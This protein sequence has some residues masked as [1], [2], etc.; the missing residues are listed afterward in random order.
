MP[1]RVRFRFNKVT[2]EVEEFLVDDQDR[3]LLPAARAYERAGRPRDAARCY[4]REGRLEDAAR[5]L[6]VAGD[7]VEAA[8]LLAHGLRR[9]A[10]ARALVDRVSAEGPEAEA[11]VALVR[12]RCDVGQGER[13]AAAAGVRDVV[14]V[15]PGLPPGPGRRRIS[16]C[17]LA[18]ADVL[19]RPDLG[20]LVLASAAGPDGTLT[21]QAIQEWDEWSLR[22]LD[23]AAAPAPREPATAGGEA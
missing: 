2:G 10:P 1:T 16:E 22:T 9:F 4:E 18:V 12:A 19:R 3:R 17:A 21:E 20:A 5:C 8:W 6:R 23:E 13:A 7:L 11:A 15:L 14:A